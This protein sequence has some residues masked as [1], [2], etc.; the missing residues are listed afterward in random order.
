MKFYTSTAK[1]LKLIVT[2]FW[3]L[4]P[5]FVDLAEVAG[6]GAFFAILNRVKKKAICRFINEYICIDFT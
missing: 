6:R 5:T 4:I 2:K 1:G 3:G